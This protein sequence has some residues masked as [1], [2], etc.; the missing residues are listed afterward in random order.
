[1]SEIRSIKRIKE[2]AEK[3]KCETEEL[4][5]PPWARSV[6]K[7]HF[8]KSQN[9]R[10]YRSHVDVCDDEE[11]SQQILAAFKTLADIAEKRDFIIL[12]GE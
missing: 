7:H 11:K 2:C 3:A 1:M 6:W 8:E 9:D 12:R 10:L 5:H 4:K